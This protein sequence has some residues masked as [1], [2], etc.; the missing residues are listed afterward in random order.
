MAAATGPQARVGSIV[1]AGLWL[2]AALIIPAAIE[3]DRGLVAGDL[4]GDGRGQ[5]RGGVVVTRWATSLDRQQVIGLAL[6]GLA[7]LAVLALIEASGT[8]DRYAAPALLLIA[9][10]AFVVIRLR[11]VFA[12]VAAGTYLIGFV[13]VRAHAAGRWDG[14]RHLPRRGRDPRRARRDLSPRAERPRRV[15]PA[16]R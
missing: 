7:G 4:R 14:P 15:R 16:P 8:A 1:A 3:I 12:L 5:P 11:F 2:V 10:F 6:N 9:I 13:V